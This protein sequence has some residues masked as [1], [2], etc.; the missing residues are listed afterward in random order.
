M[1]NM[2]VKKMIVVDE[3]I[4]ESLTKIKL[5]LSLKENKIETYSSTIS[6]LIN[7]HEKPHCVEAPA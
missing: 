2:P 7:E 3:E 6:M 4:W 5:E 1:I